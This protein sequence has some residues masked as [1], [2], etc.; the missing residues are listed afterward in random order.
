M[1]FRFLKL[2]SEAGIEIVLFMQTNIRLA[3]IKDRRKI[4]PSFLDER[5]FSGRAILITTNLSLEELEGKVGC[6]TMDR[7]IGSCRII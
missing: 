7:L 5:Y 2:C 1:K 4:P 3:K 6:R